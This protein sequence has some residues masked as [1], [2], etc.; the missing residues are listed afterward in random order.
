[1][2]VDI[3][4]R[5]VRGGGGSGQGRRRCWH[6]NNVEPYEKNTKE[7]IGGEA[8]TTR[9]A[10][11]RPEGCARSHIPK[12]GVGE[13]ESA[14]YGATVALCVLGLYRKQTKKHRSLH[15]VFDSPSA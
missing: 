1:M 4:V 7:G 6:T 13:L 5:N 14:E 3:G 15:Q 11:A 12:S 9:M 10:T 8:E 2:E